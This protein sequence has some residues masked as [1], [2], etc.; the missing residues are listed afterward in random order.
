MLIEKYKPKSLAEIVGQ[1]SLVEKI[2]QWLKDWKPKKAML[3]YGPTGIGKTIAVELI[4]KDNNFNLVEIN[5]GDDNLLSYVR[6]VLLPASKESSLFNKRLILIDE[7]DSISDRGAIAEIIDLI[8]QSATPVIITANNAYNEKLRTLRNY[9][10]LIRVNRISSVSIEKEL[11]RIATREGMKVSQDMIRRIATSSDGDIRSAIN[12]MEVAG[13]DAEFGL[14][15]REIDVFKTMKSIF[16]SNSI[17]EALQAM[18]ESDKDVDELFW[19]VEQNITMEFKSNEEILQAMELLSKADLFRSRIMVNQNYRFKKYMREMLAG[20][21]L[22]GSSRKFIMYRPPSRFIT[23]GTTKIS[24]KET[25]DFYKSL[26][27]NC[28][29]KKIKEQMPYLDMIISRQKSQ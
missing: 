6:E 23:L 20:I 13:K 24:R 2:T 15:D 14:R 8:K 12:D 27:M 21:S 1:R 4:A 22:I 17:S 9:C 11:G 19:W 28:S 5:P 26:E 7:I 10:V 3:L 25:E 29:M 16:Q 18:D